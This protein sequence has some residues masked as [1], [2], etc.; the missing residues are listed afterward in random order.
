LEVLVAPTPE[1]TVKQLNPRR[2]LMLAVILCATLM[3]GLDLFIVN[4]AMPS[5][6]QELHASFAEVQL[7]V[8]AY[9][10]AYAVLLVTG[11][12]LGDLYG[13]KRLF[14]IGVSGFTLFSA[15]CGFAPSAILLIVFRIA[16]G[17]LAALMVPQVIAFIQVSFDS[18]ERPLAFSAY[19][20]T[21]GLA[22]ILGQVIGGL[23]LAVN[24]LHTG[25]RSIFLV[26]VPI[27]IVTVIAAA[28]LV[29]E[30]RLS[31]ARRLDYG[32]VILLS[33]SLFLLVFPLVEG[34]SLGWP[35][36]SLI[37]LVLFVPA[38]ILFIA[39]EQRVARNGKLPLV[40]LLLFRRRSFTAGISTILLNGLLFSPF[41]LILAFYLQSGLRLPPLQSGLVVAAA[42]IAFMIASSGS[43]PLVRRLGNWSLP[44]A[45]ALVVLGYTLNMLTAQLLV[46]SLGIVS[47]LPALF[48]MGFG[49]GF[50]ITPLM[51]RTLAEVPS[52][53][54][55]AASGVYTTTFQTS[56]ALG[57]A[58]IGT[59]FAALTAHGGSFL[60]AFVVSLLIIAVLSLGQWFTVRPLW[61]RRRA[62]SD[63]YIG[64]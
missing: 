21:L 64:D 15:L 59:L 13:R 43:T 50:L 27:G 25:W 29:R 58:I 16:Q 62:A 41:L 56:G 34:G 48:V 37:C 26:N 44:I 8:A 4:V 60:H 7:V 23:L 6:Q 40:S 45:A 49:Q 17:A 28:L 5:I 19:T 36:W 18:S 1:E 10:L 3:A 51:N 63:E 2:W 30:S 61:A 55:G 24:L 46:S 12:R 9:A 39:Y 14:L 31:E 35:L 32:G 33:I 11:G 54:V 57:V 20:T 47:L 42:S 38:M 53:D 52:S 22:S